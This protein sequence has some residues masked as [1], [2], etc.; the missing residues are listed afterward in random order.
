MLG[1][2]SAVFR[3]VNGNGH[4][5]AQVSTEHLGLGSAIHARPGVQQLLSIPCHPAG[6]C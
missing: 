4:L 6:L 3:D 5:Q 2:I 1:N